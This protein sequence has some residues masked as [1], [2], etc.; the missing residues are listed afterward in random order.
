MNR[1]QFVLKMKE[2]YPL[3]LHPPCQSCGGEHEGVGY[4]CGSD[5]QGNGFVLWIEDDEVY[6]VLKRILPPT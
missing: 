3:T 5:E 4:L 1:K 2:N 6:Q